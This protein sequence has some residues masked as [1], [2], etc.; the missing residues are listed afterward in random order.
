MSQ[1]IKRIFLL[2]EMIHNPEVNR[3][4]RTRGVQFLQDTL[5]NSLIPLEEL[6]ND[7]IVILKNGSLVSHIS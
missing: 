1:K 6:K 2:S 3:D 7:D 4:L 5:G